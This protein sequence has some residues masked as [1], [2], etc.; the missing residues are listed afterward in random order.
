[1]ALFRCEVSKT[2]QR[3]AFKSI[4]YEIKKTHNWRDVVKGCEWKKVNMRINAP[5]LK[6]LGKYGKYMI[7]N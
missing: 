4:S 1:L 3:K 2:G 6:A 7:Q 5:K